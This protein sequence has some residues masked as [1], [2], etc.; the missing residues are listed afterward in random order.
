MTADANLVCRRCGFTNVP[1]DTFCGSCGAFLE[2]EGG[3]R[4]RARRQT[5]SS[6]LVGSPPRRPADRPARSRTRPRATRSRPP[7]PPAAAGGDRA[8]LPG[9]RRRQRG[10]PHVLPGL[11]H[12]AAEAARVGAVSQDQII[13]AV[14]A[15]NS[16]SRWATTAIRRTEPDEGSGSGGVVK[17]VAIMA[18]L[19]VII[20]VAVVSAATSSAA[21]DRRAAPR[22]RRPVVAGA[23][24]TGPPRPPSPTRPPGRRGPATTEALA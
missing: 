21:R 23:A 3:A 18:V 5:I 2:W 15:P 20:G 14:N 11:R 4:S 17:W 13:A 19:G 10:E 24:A 22:P 12:Q 8:P 6:G 16:R 7:R 1:G 9:V